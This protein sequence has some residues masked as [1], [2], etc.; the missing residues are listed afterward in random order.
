[1]TS[2]VRAIS[3]AAAALLASGSQV[4]AHFHFMGEPAYRTDFYNNAQHDTLV[5]SIFPIGCSYDEISQVD[6]V[7]YRLI[8]SQTAYST[9]ELVGYCLEGSYN[10]V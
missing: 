6:I 2:R 5:G 4:S 3:L 1:M 9:N 8:G 10:P 7:N